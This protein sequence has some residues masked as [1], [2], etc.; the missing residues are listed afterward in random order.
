[1]LNNTHSVIHTTLRF[2]EFCQSS[3][4]IIDVS[5][6]RCSDN[7]RSSVIIITII[8]MIKRHSN[9][10]NLKIVSFKSKEQ[11]KSNQEYLLRNLKKMLF[12]FICFAFNFPCK[13]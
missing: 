13:P 3:V 10:I 6:Y 1:M 4:K 11:H 7:R 5:E 12:G 2:K 8:V 9:F